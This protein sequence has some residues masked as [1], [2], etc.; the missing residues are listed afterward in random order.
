[1]GE[2]QAKVAKTVFKTGFESCVSAERGN[3]IVFFE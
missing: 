2:M 1:V 3:Y